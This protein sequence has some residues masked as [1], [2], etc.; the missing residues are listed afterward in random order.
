MSYDY[1]RNGWYCA[2]FTHEITTQPRAIRVMDEP[3]V[4]YRQHN[5]QPVALADRCPHRFA[6]LSMGKVCDDRI[7]CPYHGLRFDQSGACVH[8][9]HGN[10]AIPKAAK[11][12]AYPLVERDTIAWIWMGDPV[13]A[14]PSTILDLRDF[15]ALDT[16]SIVYGYYS[17][18]A[19]Y[20]LVLDNLMDLSH[21]PYIH[22]G[23]LSNGEADMLKMRVEM[24]QEGQQVTAYHLVD[25]SAPSPQF[26]PF[27]KG[28][29][30]VDFRANMHWSPPCSLQLDV[31]ITDVGR[32]AAE[33][34]YLHFVHLLTPVSATETHYFFAA[35]RNY[36]VGNDMVGNII[37]KNI[38]AAFVNEDEPMIEAVQGRMNGPDL[39]AQNPVLLAGDA[40]GVRVRRI[41]EQMR[42]RE[43]RT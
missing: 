15:F 20:E 28:E 14:D 23:S 43:V 33:G 29:S 9:P 11:V 2:G 32:P 35:S 16:H 18:R 6:P 24:K 19:H 12:K 25:K 30:I 1:I 27:W 41:L 4:L 39:L 36:E 21:A 37:Q 40:P 17:L 38:L 26:A 42:Q 31:G 10:H 8:N 13:L 3:I 34:I 5:G 7:E 22:K